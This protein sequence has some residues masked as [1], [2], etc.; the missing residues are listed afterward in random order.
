MDF[1]LRG[2]DRDSRCPASTDWQTVACCLQ[3]QEEDKATFLI[4]RPRPP[5]FTPH[6]VVILSDT[7]SGTPAMIFRIV[8][9]WLEAHSV[10][11]IRQ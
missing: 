4:L 2:T 6:V 10:Y 3:D 7:L 5:Y 8:D 1:L 9:Q 11:N